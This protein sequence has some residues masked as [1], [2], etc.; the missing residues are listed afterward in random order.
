MKILGIIPARGGSVG[1]KG[2]NLRELNGKPLIAW[3][4]ECALRSQLSRVIVST[5]SEEIAQV[6]KEYGADVPFLRPANLSDNTSRIEPVLLHAIN[7]LRDNEGYDYDAIAL[8]FPTHPLRNI[9][10]INDC[11]EGFDLAT[12]DSVVSVT[13]A[14]ANDNPLWML[15]ENSENRVVLFNDKPLVEIEDRRQ[16]LPCVYKRNDLV[17]I[18][19]E[20]NLLAKK[21]S[22]YGE[23]VKLVT[24]S[25]MLDV[26]IN[27]EEDWK[28]LQKI[29]PILVKDI[30]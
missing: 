19:K 12:H 14:I 30:A 26:D 17:Y 5:E 29:F 6:A 22:L 16:D 8:I 28:L 18:L 23:K 2:K 24:T 1:V 13:P 25:N 11:I 3:T 27:T 20:S 7:W 15:K 9:M 4:I 10:D 21:I